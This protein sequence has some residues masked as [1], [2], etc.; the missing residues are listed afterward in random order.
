MNPQSKHDKLDITIKDHSYKLEIMMNDEYLNINVTNNRSKNYFYNSY[1]HSEILSITREAGFLS[2][3][4]QLYQMLIEGASVEPNKEIAINLTIENT[5]NKQ[6]QKMVLELILTFGGKLN[7]VYRY[8]FEL[9]KVQRSMD[10]VLQEVLDD[11]HILSERITNLE[12][13]SGVI[14]KLENVPALETL[15]NR[16]DELENFLVTI[17]N[18]VETGGISN[19]T[20]FRNEIQNLG[21]AKKD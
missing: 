21:W 4:E 2:N 19:R 12:K 14:T 15:F 13:L 8:V 11:F 10:E 20:S 1:S 5:E 16:M 3:T 17:R 18:L 7:R 6:D 9:S